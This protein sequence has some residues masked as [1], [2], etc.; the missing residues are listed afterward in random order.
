[1]QF[2]PSSFSGFSVPKAVH[3]VSPE[4]V[5]AFVSSVVNVTEEEH[6]RI[7]ELPQ[8]DPDGSTNDDWIEARK[9]RFT[10]SAAGAFGL[11]NPY[12]SCENYIEKKVRP[13]EMDARGKAYC[14]WGNAHEDDC[15][16]AF[17]EKYLREKLYEYTRN[18][19]DLFLPERM[20]IHHLGLYICKAPGLAMLGMSPD[21]ILETHWRRPDGT[22]YKVLELC[23]WKCP[24]TWEKK[25]DNSHIYKS[26]LL[27]STFP[28]RL[29]KQMGRMPP[30]HE[31]MRYRLPVPPYY[32]SQIQYGMA[33]FRKSGVELERAWFGV[34]DPN[35]VAVTCIP[36]D[37][38]Y[39]EWIIERGRTVWMNEYV[40]K[41]LEHR[42]VREKLDVLRQDSA[43]DSA[44]DECDNWSSM[45]SGFA[46]VPKR[47][48]NENGKRIRS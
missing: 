25:Q 15:E 9:H 7:R 19:G 28:V 27:P 29:Q 30:T 48:I 10:G 40:P 36:R 39:G 12:E 16:D 35:R 38:A 5:D 18:N 23:E 43:D 34:W 32:F 47:T 2:S 21:G 8:H 41:L 24:A 1:M 22:E 33:L 31:G 46:A 20:K 13:V 17:K 37:D 45:F 3:V 6:K 44:M 42:K 4:E 26:N 11:Q 14:A